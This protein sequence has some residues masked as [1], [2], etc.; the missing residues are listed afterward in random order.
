MGIRLV[1]EE[2]I[3]SLLAD[4]RTPLLI[5]VMAPWCTVCQKM[6][7]ELNR[8]AIERGNTIRFAK[9]DMDDSPD[10]ALALGQ[11]TWKTVPLLILFKDGQEIARRG[12]GTYDDLSA[13]LTGYGL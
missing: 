13:W 8:L 5:D 11:P 2:T 9:V 12:S 3:S 7:P 1:T 6:E 10:V 4:H